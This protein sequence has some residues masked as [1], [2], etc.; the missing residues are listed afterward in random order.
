MIYGPGNES[1]VASGPSKQGAV[2][3]VLACLFGPAPLPTH[4]AA[5]S[6]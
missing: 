4:V 3:L 6:S 5:M 2:I 1:P